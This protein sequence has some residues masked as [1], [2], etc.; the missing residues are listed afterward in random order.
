MN[1]YP[2]IGFWKRFVAFLV[3]IIIVSIPPAII[4]LPFLYQQINSASQINETD[5]AFFGA[6]LMVFFVYAFWVLLNLVCFWLYFALL[7]SGAKQATLGKRLLRIKVIGKDGKRIS[8]ALATGR[9]F[10]KA[11]SYIT[12]YIGFI[13]A[14]FTNR[15]R[16]LHDYIVQT[17]V[18]EQNF[19][20]GDEL[21]DTPSHLVW[22]WILSIIAGLLLI[23]SFFLGILFQMQS[24]PMQAA[25]ASLRLQM[26]AQE[27][28]SLAQPL[29]EQSIIYSQTADGY[30]AVFKTFEEEE[31]AILLPK[32]SQ[33]VC[34]QSL[35]GG[36]CTQTGVPACQ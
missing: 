31:F 4:C 10:A 29:Q 8:F 30:S 22:L 9:F 20:E 26:L 24:A 15:K 7:E 6:M 27:Q 16:T 25:V 5:P 19:Q 36:D 28:V 2:Y 3:D 17:Y 12:F 21:P 23:G 18:V 11:L 33:T 35:S 32:G 14:G 1:K 34:C 13:M